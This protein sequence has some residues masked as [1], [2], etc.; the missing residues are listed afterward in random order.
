MSASDVSS[1]ARMDLRR[2]LIVLGLLLVVGMT[3]TA[4]ARIGGGQAGICASCQRK[5]TLGRFDWVVS[6]IEQDE[7]VAAG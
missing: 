3:T 1:A 7:E 2:L 4:Q 6:R 5:V